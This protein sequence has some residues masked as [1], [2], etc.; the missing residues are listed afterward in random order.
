M[1][2]PAA[3]VYEPWYSPRSE[4]SIR[5]SHAECPNCHHEWRPYED[6]MPGEGAETEHQ[7]P[8]CERHV[9]LHPTYSLMIYACPEVEDGAS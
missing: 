9:M 4:F 2:E 3:R 5:C 6:E 1:S 8:K 7:C